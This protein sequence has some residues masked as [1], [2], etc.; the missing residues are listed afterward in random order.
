MAHATQIAAGTHNG[1]AAR[2]AAL[3]ETFRARNAKRKI[4]NQTYR[5]LAGLTDRDLS[6]LGLSRTEIRRVAWQA[7][8]EV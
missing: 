6:D 1:L 4:Y 7:A 3:T 2:F 8:Y 5:E